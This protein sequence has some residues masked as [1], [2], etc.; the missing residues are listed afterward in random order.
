MGAMMPAQFAVIGTPIGHS[1]SVLLHSAVYR[2]LGTD[3]QTT[4]VDPQDEE[5]FQ[6]L[7][8][9]I[10]CGA[11]EILGA[12]V[13]IPYKE[14]AA[15]LCDELSEA[16]QRCG[17]VNTLLRTGAGHLVGHNSDMGGFL[18]AL[19]SELGIS[20]PRLGRVAVC[21]TGGVARA[22]TAAL[23]SAGVTDILVVS[24]DRRR[25][26]DFL[27]ALGAGGTAVTY[28]DLVSAGSDAGVIDL[29]VNA[30]P[31]GM[32]GAGASAIPAAFYVWLQQHTL[33]VFDAVYRRGETTPLVAWARSAQ[34]PAAD[35]LMMLVEQA[36]ISLRFWGLAAEPA[37]LR[38]IMVEALKKE[39]IR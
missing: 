22:I 34:I 33:A 13:T 4:A 21:G 20:A 14:V 3:W 39:G 26:A 38:A 7:V 12:N 1:L 9:E 2:A 29:C 8:A 31:V 32:V 28:E 30:T 37:E 6:R 15:G 24:R 27:A 23:S 17:A 36:I 19:A 35:G 18:A 11:T 25:G 5:G 10:R 16:A